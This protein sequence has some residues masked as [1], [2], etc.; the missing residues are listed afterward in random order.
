MTIR[1]NRSRLQLACELIGHMLR[2]GN[3][4]SS[5]AIHRH[6]SSQLSEGDFG[7]AK[8]ALGIEHR[9]VMGAD[10]HREVQWRLPENPS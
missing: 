5:N 6:L 9:W 8:M 1:T 10:G 4:R 7:R 3:W 2:D